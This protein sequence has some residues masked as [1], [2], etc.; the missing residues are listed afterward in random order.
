MRAPAA[1]ALALALAA[2][3]AARAEW[4]YLVEEATTLEAGR[5][6]LS[7]G[8]AFSWQDVD[9]LLG[10][11]G[12]RWSVPQVEASLGVGPAA[13]VSA[14]YE[15]L[16]FDPADERDWA[17]GSG[18]LRLWTKLGLF[19]DQVDG[20][21]LRFG[22]KL[23]NASETRGLG[24]DETDFLAS[25]LYARGVG[26]AVVTLNAGL[27][28]LGSPERNRSQDD[29]WTWGAQVRA[30]AGRWFRFGL[31]AVGQH[32]PFGLEVKRDFVT[33]AGVAEVMTGPWRW[34]VSGRRGIQDALSWGWAAGVS[35]AP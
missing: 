35:W 14:A 28:L 34:S 4:P 3:P 19:P 26:P 16:G 22:V 8:V 30:P 31:E 15:F 32:G 2:V 27:G 18:D 33:L 6:S 1:F 13:E 11:R 12:R 21:A 10:G 29:V 23:P 17:S 5:V 24:T 9:T 25:L 7:A 20:L